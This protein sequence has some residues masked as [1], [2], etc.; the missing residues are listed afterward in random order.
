VALEGHP[1]NVTASLFGGCT[2]CHPAPAGPGSA[3]RFFHVPLSPALRYAVAWP[4]EPLATARAR[5]ALP[6]SVPFADAVENPRRLALLV[7]GLRTG[8][9]ELLALGGEERLH[10]R[11]RLPLIPGA[12]TALAAARD[13]GAYLAT[14][15]GAGSGLFAIGPAADIAAVAEALRAELERAS[16]KGTA[17][18]VEPVLGSPVVEGAREA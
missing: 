13:A 6:E 2:L 16:G 15:S 14:I 17:R 18:I 12:K 7:E 8:D 11:W 10:E 5:A 3:P 4:R 9:P 1:D